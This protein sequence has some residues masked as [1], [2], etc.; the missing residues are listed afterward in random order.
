[1][2]IFRQ[3]PVVCL[4]QAIG[5]KSVVRCHIASRRAQKNVFKS[6]HEDGPDANLIAHVMEIS[7]QVPCGLLPSPPN[8]PQGKAVAL[9]PKRTHLMRKDLRLAD[10]A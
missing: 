3:L 8:Y 2:E 1:M 5:R 9:A 7:Q 10:V 6:P 4:A